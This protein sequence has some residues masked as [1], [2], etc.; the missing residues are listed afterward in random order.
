M[1]RSA[2]I[3]PFRARF[4]RL[5]LSN[6]KKA[7]RICRRF[8]FVS[9]SR[10]LAAVS[11]ARFP[12]IA[13]RVPRSRPFPFRSLLSRRSSSKRF[14]ILKNF[15]ACKGVLVDFFKISCYNSIANRETADF[16]RNLCRALSPFSVGILSANGNPGRIS[17]Q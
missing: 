17:V 13:S 15:F 4:F 9:S 7:A 14:Q 11:D 3:C 5:F 12:P 6:E 10:P 2:R 8:V 1:P 16:L